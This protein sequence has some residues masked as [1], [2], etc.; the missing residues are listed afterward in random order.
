MSQHWSIPRTLLTWLQLIFSCSLDWNR[1]WKDSAFVILLT[2]LRM[3]WKSWKGFYKMA[4]R[5][6]SNIFT[7]TGRSVQLHKGTTVMETKC[8]WLYSL[9][10]LGNK[11]ILGTFWSYHI[12][13][14]CILNFAWECMPVYCPFIN[15]TELGPDLCNATVCIWTSW[16]SGHSPTLY[17]VGSGFKIWLRYQVPWLRFFCCLLSHSK[18]MTG[19]YLV[20]IHYHFNIFNHHSIILAI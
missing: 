16:L 4:S 15:L 7:V 9:V 8:K 12:L 18:Q 6:V 2:S 13:V 10:F 11:V 19:Q 3:Q 1:H 14:T 20:L 5:N 17:L